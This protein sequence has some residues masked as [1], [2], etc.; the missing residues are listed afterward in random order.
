M[1]PSMH[2]SARW[3]RGTRF[4]SSFFC[5]AALVLACTSSSSGTPSGGTPSGTTPVTD[6]GM[7]GCAPLEQGCYT[8]SG[9]FSPPNVT[10]TCAMPGGPATGAAD[11]HCNGATPQTTSASSCG[12]SDAGPTPDAGPAPDAGPGPTPGPCAE[13]GPNYGAT[14]Y[15]SEADDDDCKYHVSYTSTPTCQKDGIYLTV[16]ATHLTDQSPLSGAC[17]FAELCLSDTHPAPNSDSRPPTGSQTVVEGPPGT[18]TIGPV[19]F[20]APGDWTVRFHFNEICCDTLP[21]SPH[22]HAAFHVIVP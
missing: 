14:M 10:P 12:V 2:W 22:G 5:A 11:T 20:D 15:G 7:V 1:M 21:T 19:T 8:T 3:T 17:T 4:L 6:A 18:Y 9:A 16:Q 13:N